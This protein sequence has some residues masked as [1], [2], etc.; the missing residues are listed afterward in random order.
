MGLSVST[1]KLDVVT[2]TCNPCLVYIVNSR[3]V[4]VIDQDPV[5]TTA[6]TERTKRSEEKTRQTGRREGGKKGEKEGGTRQR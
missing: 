5:P 1:F 6:Q 3:L 2:H 4:R